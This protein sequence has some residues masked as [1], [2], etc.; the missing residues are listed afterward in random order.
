MCVLCACVCTP[1]PYSLVD[2]TVIVTNSFASPFRP[3]S[4]PSRSWNISTKAKADDAPPTGL[5]RIITHKSHHTRTRT[6]T[7]PLPQTPPP[8]TAQLR[9]RAASSGYGKVAPPVKPRA[10]AANEPT[11]RPGTAGPGLRRDPPPV[12]KNAL[13]SK[14]SG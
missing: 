9:L 10:P 5:V 12:P 11:W 1:P 13:T 14:V 3:A 7:Y 4:A 8:S 2:V 6:D